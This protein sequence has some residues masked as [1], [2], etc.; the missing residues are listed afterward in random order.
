MALAELIKDAPDNDPEKPEL[1]EHLLTT[2]YE[3]DD[4]VRRI[5]KKTEHANLVNFTDRPSLF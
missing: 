2:A 1:L 5:S 3:L 4:Q